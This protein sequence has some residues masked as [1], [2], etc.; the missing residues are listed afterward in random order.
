MSLRLREGCDLARHAALRG[1]KLN[2]AALEEDEFL[3]RDGNSIKVTEKG[4]PL[5]N[6]IIEKLIT[7]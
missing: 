5:L 3:V 2:S 6:R 1:S 7:D 4:L